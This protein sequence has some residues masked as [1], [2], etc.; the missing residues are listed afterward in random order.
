M[1]GGPC[2]LTMVC[3]PNDVTCAYHISFFSRSDIRTY[4]FDKNNDHAFQYLA[5]SQYVYYIV[6]HE[7]EIL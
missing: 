3:R 6:A 2:M 4:I 7:I 1:F 5:Q